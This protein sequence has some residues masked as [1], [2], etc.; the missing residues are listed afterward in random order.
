MALVLEIILGLM[1][2]A[3]FFVAYMSAQSWKIYQVVLLVFIF[4][5]TVAFFYL[6]A[7]T[8]ATHNS[9]RTLV[10]QRET[11][12]T[13]IEQQIQSAKAGGQPGA[14]GKPEKG[15]QQLVR[16]LEVLASDRGG[17]LTD[18]TIDS[19]KDSTVQLTFKSAP[20]L[21]V[22]AVVFA[23]DQTPIAEGG[24]YRG[25]FKVTTVD[26]AAPTVQL[27]PNL[28]LDAAG[29]EQ[30][31]S[32]KGPWMLYTSMPIDDASVFAAL[33]EATRQKMLPQASLAEWAKADRSLRDFER[34][35]HDSYHDSSLLTD[36]IRKL[37]GNI[38]RTEAAVKKAEEEI[39]YRKTEKTNLAADLEK[40]Q[41]EQKT[42]ADY[43]QSLE[44]RL[45]EVRQLLKSTF[46]QNRTLATRWTEEQL[47]AAD[48]IN[49]RTAAATAPGP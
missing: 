29:L 19:V 49:R 42:I 24:R 28:P 40:F 46:L 30:L 44:K 13:G 3:S 25:E 45:Q 47:R 16:E 15:I 4:L 10:K 31:K 21:V 26:E 41:F 6:S 38:E 20:G 48:E 22:G 8:L 9:W 36:S 17:L 27:E 1:I 12:A 35:F 23:F 39:A 37:T 18:G 11:E 5:G 34:I 32:A 14:D 7:R 2:L 33:D 43:E